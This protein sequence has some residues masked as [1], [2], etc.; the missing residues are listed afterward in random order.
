MK[1]ATSWELGFMS[2]DVLRSAITG[3]LIAALM[4]PASAGVADETT[5]GFAALMTILPPQPG[6]KTCYARNYDAAHLRAH[7]RQRI[8]AMNFLLTVKA[9]DPKPA[10]KSAPEDL[11]Y[12]TFAMSVVRRGD[13]RLLHTA[14]DCMSGEEISCVVDCDGGSVALDNMPPAGS[15]IVRLNNE[16]GITMFHDCDEGKGIVVKA[17]ADDKVFHL[18]KA[19]AAACSALEDKD[20]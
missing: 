5:P 14:G 13:K 7:P 17:G 6:G 4:V 10:D 15:L 12:Y 19:A 3:L 18:D 20:D 8:T 16:N 11:Y 2:P 9:Y 1:R